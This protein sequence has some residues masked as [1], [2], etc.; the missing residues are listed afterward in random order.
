MLKVCYK[1]NREN[2][3][4]LLFRPLVEPFDST[5]MLDLAEANHLK[6]FMGQTCC[7]TKLQEIWRGN[8]AAITPWYK[9]VVSLFLPFCLQLI[10][11]REGNQN[12]K[13]RFF[14]NCT[15]DNK[16]KQPQTG[17]GKD[18]VPLSKALWYLYSAPLSVFILNTFFYLWF[19]VLFSYFVLVDLD[20]QITYTEWAVWGWIL[21]F[22]YDECRQIANSG[23]TCDFPKTFCNWIIS[24]WNKFDLFMFGTIIVT[25]ALRFSLVGIDFEYVRYAYSFSVGMFYLRFLQN[26][27]VHENIGPKVLMIGKMMIDL[28][29]F[30][31]IGLV[32]VLCFGIIYQANLYP[33][34]PA[35]EK[36]LEKIFFVPYWQIFGELFLDELTGYPEGYCTSNETIWR[37]DG[38]NGRCPE[39][40]RLV[41]IIGGVYIFLTNIVLVNLLIAMFSHTFDA[42]QKKSER[43]W[44]FYFYRLINEYRNKPV[45]FPPL[46]IV[47]FVYHHMDAQENKRRKQEQ[48]LQLQKLEL[49]ENKMKIEY[50]KEC[51]KRNNEPITQI[52]ELITSKITED[53]QIS[54]EIEDIFKRGYL[55]YGD[56]HEA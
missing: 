30:L 26:C 20:E 28:F 18:V 27:F 16:S 35:A 5:A 45:L 47:M 40:R 33:N 39:I 19:L 9:I 31:G 36:L 4:R 50:E 43:I 54:R 53:K 41:P 23:K 49:F 21:I 11:F 51:L 12:N 25:L 32:F 37:A 17:E 14:R 3:H 2:A 15:S 1:H 8:I 13:V 22:L 44:R 29:Q 46:V 6:T 34:S 7:Q 52:L 48:E 10:T 56:E 24:P 38:G 55:H 42:I